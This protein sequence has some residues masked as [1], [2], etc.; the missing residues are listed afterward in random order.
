MEAD[1]DE[2]KSTADC[3][4]EKLFQELDKE[5]STKLDNDQLD[6]ITAM[7]NEYQGYIKSHLIEQQEKKSSKADRL[8]DHIASFGGSWTFI[9]LFCAFLG[10]WMVINL[11]SFSFDKPPFI[12]LNLILSCVSA[13]QA[14]VIL[15]SQ[16]RQ[17]ARDKQEAILDFAINYRAEQENLELKVL[18]ERLNK[19]LERLEEMGLTRHAERE[20][21]R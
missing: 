6:R 12:L 14:P 17:A 2:K 11:M 5:P 9:V 20:H 18:L 4:P 1:I 19:K 13:L 10:I 16:N 15:M 8:A 7:V 21:N 3:T